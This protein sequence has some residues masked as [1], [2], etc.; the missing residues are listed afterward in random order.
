MKTA[1]IT[2]GGM[3]TRLLTYT[4]DNPK[5][6]VP[7]FGKNIKNKKNPFVRP[8]VEIVFDNLYQ[9]GFR[10]FC[11]ITGAKGASIKHHFSYDHEIEN[12]LKSRDL[13]VD[14]IFLKHLKQLDKKVKKCKIKWIKQNTPM[15]FGDALLRAEKHIEGKNFLLH[16]GDVFI[17][18]YRFLKKF[19]KTFES[20]KKTAGCLLLQQKPKNEL[21]AYGIAKVDS[22]KKKYVIDVEEKPKIPNSNLVILPLYI[23]DKKIFSALQKTKRGYANELQLTDGIKMLIESCELIT[24][25]NFKNESWFDIGTPQNYHNA[26][27]HSYK[28]AIE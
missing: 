22:N 9:Q 8:L 25:Y 10:N 6:M 11:F 24:N 15:G 20:N 18:E 3:G 7:I 5:S 13:P 4:K 19:I 2:T 1:V 14:R 17:P 28:K 12:I 27:N 16:A 21:Y 26:I 23:F